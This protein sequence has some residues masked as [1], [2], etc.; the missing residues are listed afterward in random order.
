MKIKKALLIM[1]PAFTFKGNRD[2]NPLPPMGLGYIA[3]V[4]EKMDIEVKIIDCLVRGWDTELEVSDLLIRVGLT[5]EEIVKIIKDFDPDMIGVTCHF[6]RQYKIYH[7]MFEIAKKCKPGCITIAGG[8]HVTVNPEEVLADL[9]CDYIIM[10]EAE[11]SIKIFIEKY[12]TGNSLDGID[13][14]GYKLNGDPK[15][16][17][18]KS[19]IENLD[20]IPFPAHHLMNLELYYGLEASHGERH[21]EKFIPV[22]TSRGCPAKC[23]FCSALKVWGNRFRFR[24]V[25]N[26]LQEMRLLKDKYGIEEIMFEDDNVTAKVKRAKELFQGMIRE[27]LNFVWDTPNGVGIWSVDEEM[28]D[29]MK[30]AGC[31]KLNFPVESGSQYVLDNIIKKPLDLDKVKK[32]IKHCR[33]IGLDYGMFL[34]MGM[35]GEKISDMWKSFKFA[36]ECGVYNP[37]ISIATPYPGTQLFDSC[38]NDGLFTRQF[39]LDDLF[40]RSYLIKTKDWDGDVLQKMLIKGQ[41]YLRIRSFTNIGNLA[42]YIFNSLIHPIYSIK[43]WSANISRLFRTK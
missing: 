10:G 25:E 38:I 43:K 19:W 13:G 30:E 32:L 9:N 36:A 17:Y 27:K 21:K 14:L 12:E 24:S 29:L 1:P 40:I 16:N 4:L 7:E 6:S 18:K 5:N 35:P 20:S 3:A 8:A 28:I 33:K 11:E 22:V 41:L 26:V 15:I 34:V 39:S 31:V 37:M 2:I 42:K 23:T